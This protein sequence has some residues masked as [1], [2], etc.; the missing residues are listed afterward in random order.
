MRTIEEIDA[1]IRD[2]KL[3][4]DQVKGEPTEVYSRI[5]GYYRSLRNWNPGKREEFEHRKVFSPNG[6][7]MTN[8]TVD[9]RSA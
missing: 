3:K 1:E 9:A 8:K 7:I 6:Y 5:V 4:L 2:L